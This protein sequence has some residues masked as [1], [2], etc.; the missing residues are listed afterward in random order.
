[1]FYS[2]AGSVPVLTIA[3]VGLL[4]IQHYRHRPKLTPEQGRQLDHADNL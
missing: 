4:N 3:L 2:I 1:M